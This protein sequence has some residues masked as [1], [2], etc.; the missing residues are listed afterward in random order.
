LA[1]GG[2]YRREG[3]IDP[4]IDRTECFFE[5]GRCGVHLVEVRHVGLNRECLATFPLN[6]VSDPVEAQLSSGDEAHLGPASSK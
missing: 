6:L 4:H 1:E 5:P 3:N 2:E